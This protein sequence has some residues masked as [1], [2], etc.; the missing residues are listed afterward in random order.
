MSHNERCKECKVRVRQLLEKIFGPVI[1]NYRIHLGTCP[2]ELR[3]HP[4]YSVLNDIYTALQDHR[5]FAEFVRAVYVD[6]DFFLPEQKMIVEFDESQHFSEPRKIVLSHY[7][8]DL[9]LGFPRDTWIK[10]CDEIRAY[11]N[12][13][14][15]RDEQRAWYDTLRDFIPEMKGFRPTV[16]LFARDI[17][18]CSLDVNNV[19][20]IQ[21]F[22]NLIKIDNEVGV[23]NQSDGFS[24]MPK[25]DWIATV[26][27]KSNLKIADEK[28][29]SNNPIRLFEMEQI[30]G[31][32]LEKTSGDG[33]ILFPGG[34]VHTQH[35]RAETIYPEIE[36]RVREILTQTDRNI[37]VCIG[38]DGFFDRP[39]A[40]DPFDQDQ[41]AIT[42]D[43]TGIIAICRKFYPSDDTERKSIILA[44]NCFDGELGKPRI[45][46]LNGIRYFPFVCYDVYGPWH[47]PQKFPKPD[48]DIGLNLIHRFRPKGEFLCQE[49]YF[50][51]NGWSEASYQWKIPVF[52]TSIFF[53][54]SI[55]S[56]WPTGIFWTGGVVWKKPSYPDITLPCDKP[57]ITMQLAEGSAEVRIFTDIPGKIQSMKRISQEDITKNNPR[58]QKRSLAVERTNTGITDPNGIYAKLRKELDIFFGKSI[59]DQK[60]KYTYRAENKIGYPN[61]KELDMISLFKPTMNA[62]D[63]VRFRVYPHILAS[64]SGL[65]N[66]DEIIAVLPEGSIIKQEREDPHLGD[67][68]IEGVFS[69]EEEIEK[70]V[71]WIEFEK[72]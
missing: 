40:E 30:L 39:I 41:I 29:P 63:R 25:Q 69:N 17:A 53:R 21:E 20:D 12:D 47:E 60:S 15:F 28:D 48:A 49:N 37:K 52:G 72:K 67:I 58:I 50:P 23:T 16:R 18:W 43:K 8:S 34:W 70:F 7:P 4:R 62:P 66:A 32:T 2:E 45:F 10:H 33:V 27:L 54:R 1:P 22:Q 55:P 56:D 64:L 38:I 35:D 24:Q 31:S 3:E 65:R 57:A 26:I 71:K 14:P 6:V 5:G 13:P 9:N 59:I 51:L 19:N 44:K 68:F 42:I 36:R 61:K 11:D 46:E